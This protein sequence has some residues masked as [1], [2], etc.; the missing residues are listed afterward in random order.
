[1]KN[2]ECNFKLY[3]AYFYFSHKKYKKM[4]KKCNIY[5]YFRENGIKC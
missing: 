2:A 5:F 4:R 1:M 3:F